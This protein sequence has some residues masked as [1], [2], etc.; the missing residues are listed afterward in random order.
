MAFFSFFFVKQKTAYEMRISDWSSD[1]CSSDLDE[2]GEA[3]AVG[4]PLPRE[5]L[6]GALDAGERILDLVRQH[7]GGGARDAA[8][9]T[10]GAAHQFRLALRRNE[11]EDEIGRAHV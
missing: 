4:D 5:E 2:G 3:F 6:R 7:G 9:T 8:R 11:R 10:D 1:V